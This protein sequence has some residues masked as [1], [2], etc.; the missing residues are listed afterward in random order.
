MTQFLILYALTAAVKKVLPVFW[1]VQRVLGINLRSF[2]GGKLGVSFD[3]T[4]SGQDV[5]DL[6]SIFSEEDWTIDRLE[7]L[8]QDLPADLESCYEEALARQTSY[9][10]HPVFSSYQSETAMMRYLSSLASKDVSLTTS[11]M[12]LGSCTMKLNAASE[13]EPVSWPGFCQYASISASSPMRGI[14]KLD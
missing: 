9:L 6:L 5:C 4:A 14:Q 3:E 13:M 10:D 1:L 11:M 7:S 8:L 2:G 12:L